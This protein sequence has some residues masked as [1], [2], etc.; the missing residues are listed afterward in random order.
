ML[1]I[2]FCVL[3]VGQC[4]LVLRCALF[5]CDVARNLFL[6]SE[7][8]YWALFFWKFGLRISELEVICLG[9][10]FWVLLFRV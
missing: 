10:S 4:K 2:S 5:V 3:F 7:V 1:G 8:R 9:F 6:G